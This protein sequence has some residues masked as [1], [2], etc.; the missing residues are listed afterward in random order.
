MQL[1]YSGGRDEVRLVLAQWIY[2]TS[3]LQEGNNRCMLND[4]AMK[5]GFQKK[6]EGFNVD[7]KPSFLVTTIA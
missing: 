4:M 1:Y 3:V 6:K 2:G 5:D 7:E